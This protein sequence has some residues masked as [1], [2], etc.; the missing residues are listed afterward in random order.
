MMNSNQFQCA[1][2]KNIYEKGRPDEVAFE[3]TQAVFG[4]VRME[5]CDVVCD[6]CFKAIEPANHP[7]LVE[8]SVALPEKP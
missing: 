1:M 2:C 3:E 8:E 7:H 5:D 4:N 6:A